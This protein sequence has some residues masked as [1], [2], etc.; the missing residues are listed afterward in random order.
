MVQSQSVLWTW[1]DQESEKH[2]IIHVRP[3]Q[4]EQVITIFWAPSWAIGYWNGGA[5]DK[6]GGVERG[7]ETHVGTPLYFE[8]I[9]IGQTLFNYI[10]FGFVIQNLIRVRGLSAFDSGPVTSSSTF[11]HTFDM[12]GTYFIT[13]E[14]TKQQLCVIDVLEKRKLH[15]GGS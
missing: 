8:R 9:F 11:F 15:T 4:A 5:K 10:L 2:N 3:P 6:R 14:G 1:K 12:P 13:S 7:M